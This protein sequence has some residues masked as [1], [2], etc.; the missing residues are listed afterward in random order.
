VLGILYNALVVIPI[1]LFFT[2]CIRL[3]TSKHFSNWCLFNSFDMGVPSNP[4][5]LWWR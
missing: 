3:V 5:L 2:I 4:F 1:S